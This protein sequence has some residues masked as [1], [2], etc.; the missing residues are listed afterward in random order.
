M[1]LVLVRLV[2]SSCLSSST[3]A[4]LRGFDCCCQ[5]VGKETKSDDFSLGLGNELSLETPWGSA[6][7]RCGAKLCGC[8]WFGAR[9]SRAAFGGIW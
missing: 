3:T 2:V 7:P 4:A 1:P 8:S 5:G 9:A 6:A